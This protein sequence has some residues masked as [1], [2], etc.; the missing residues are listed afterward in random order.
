MYKYL[1]QGELASSLNLVGLVAHFAH[2]A[3]YNRDKHSALNLYKVSGSQELFTVLFCAKIRP[4]TIIFC[5]VVDSHWFN[6]APVSSLRIQIRIKGDVPI[7]IHAEPDPGKTF[8]LNFTRK[9]NL[10]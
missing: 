5:S 4:I 6:C 8:R 10:K 1:G 2:Q 9:L 7:R 3:F